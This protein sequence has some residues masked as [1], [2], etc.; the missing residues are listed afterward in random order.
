MPEGE[1]E[2]ISLWTVYVYSGVLLEQQ[3]GRGS[4]PRPSL[5][6]VCLS[7]FPPG[8]RDELSEAQVAIWGHKHR[9]YSK[10]SNLPH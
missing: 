2:A 7:L 3:G 9:L 8:Q 1:T 4:D 10:F 6:S 5:T